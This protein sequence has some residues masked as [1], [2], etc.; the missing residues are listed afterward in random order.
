MEAKNASNITLDEIV[1]EGRNKE[2]GAYSLRKN[3]SRYLTKASVIGIGIFGGAL[4]AAWSV[5]KFG[6]NKEEELQTVEI[7]LSKLK[8]EKQEEKKPDIPP[9]PPEPEPPKQEIA[10]I[11]FIPPEPKADEEVK[12]EEPPPKVEEVENK[13]ISNVNKEGV[14]TEEVAAAP[15]PVEAPKPAEIAQPKEDEIFTTVEQQPEFPGGL[16]EMYAFIGKNLK[17]PSAAQRAN[18]SGRVFAKFVVEKDGRIGD[19]QILKGIGFGCDEEAQRVIK[20][21]PKWNPGKQNG[22]SVRVF[23]TMPINFQLE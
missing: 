6:G 9:P 13:V 16:K 3:Y 17:Y 11:K 22:R 10:Q 15:P 7:D 19:V 18:I 5:N 23:F 1:F 8:E 14:E 20:S 12:N 21:M 4:L 2:Y